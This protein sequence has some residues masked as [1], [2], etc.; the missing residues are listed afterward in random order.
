MTAPVQVAL[1][2]VLALLASRESLARAVGDLGDRDR[3]IAEEKSIA[4]VAAG[5]AV[6]IVDDLGIQAG[7]IAAA[8]RADVI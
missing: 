4:V 1:R 2:Q 5:R 8:D 6:V 7:R 3:V